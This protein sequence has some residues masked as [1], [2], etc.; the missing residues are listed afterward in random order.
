M[1]YLIGSLKNPRVPEL[2]NLLREEG[3]EVFDEWHG[4]GPEAD[5]FWQAY[6]KARGRKFAEALQGHAAQHICGFDK[7]FLDLC[8]AAVLVM[9]AGK[10]GHLELGYVIGSRKPAFILLD[11]EPERFD[12][13]YALATGVFTTIDQLLERLHT[14]RLEKAA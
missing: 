6:E 9:P 3:T 5:D 8:D 14:T 11:G 13:M 12:V 4:A 1:V 7:K 10:S 2:A